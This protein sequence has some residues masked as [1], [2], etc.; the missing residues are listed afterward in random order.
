MKTDYK[1]YGFIFYLEVEVLDNKIKRKESYC[2]ILKF[3]LQI[4]AHSFFRF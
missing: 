2:D 4:K 3:C 1:N